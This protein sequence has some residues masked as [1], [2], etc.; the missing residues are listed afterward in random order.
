MDEEDRRQGVR[1]MGRRERLM[2]YNTGEPMCSQRRTDC[3]SFSNG[4]CMILTD[5]KFDRDCPFY[6]RKER[7]DDKDSKNT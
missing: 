1:E 6:K 5:T 3:K 2:M 4:R 7:K